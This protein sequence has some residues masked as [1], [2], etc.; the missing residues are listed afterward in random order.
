MAGYGKT[1]SVQPYILAVLGEHIEY[2]SQSV[3]KSLSYP[4][5]WP[6]L[7]PVVLFYR[8]TGVSTQGT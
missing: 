3:V 6:P 5:H 4:P 1:V 8:Q 7:A 2:L